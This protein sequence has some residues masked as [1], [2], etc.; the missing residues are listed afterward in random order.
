MSSPTGAI[1]AP[2]E[3]ARRPNR[4]ELLELVVEGVAHG[5]AGVARLERY[6]LFVEGAFPGERVRAEVTRSKRD[7]AHARAV[8]V[9]DPSPDRV[10]VRCDHEGGECPGSPWQTLRYERQLEHKEELVGDALRRIGGLEGFE[11][12]PIVAAAD[13]W[14]YRNKTEYSF[15]ARPSPNPSAGLPADGLL[16]GFHARGRW[17]RVNDARDCLLASERN[18]AVRNFVRDWCAAQG[19]DPLDRRTQTGFLRNLVVREGRRTGDLQVRLVTSPGEFDVDGLG[20]ALGERFPEASFL[21]TRTS[22]TA[23]VTDDGTTEVVSG[24]DTLTERLGDLEFNISPDAFF[25]PNTETAESLYALACDYAD[26]RGTE[27]VYDLFCGIGTLSLTLAMRAGEVWGVELVEEAVADAIRNAQLNEID[28]THFFH[29]DVRDSV[30][31]L[32]ERAPRPDVV[33][34]DPPRA[35][36]SKKVVRRLI[37]TRP[38]RIVYVSC[39]PTTLAPNAAQMAE[40]G[41]RLARVR[42]VDMFPHTPHIECVALLERTEGD[43]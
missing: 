23:E 2:P 21:W 20:D 35:G 32:A 37:E 4:G 33:V 26:L 14:R 16:L 3:R 18:N 27:R 11:L 6:V 30:R 39:N 19:L 42:P 28:N 25:Q 8:E 15:G 12:E 29:G 9:L 36:L 43:G 34:V 17:D 10:P 22:A 41:Y 38:R 40:A 5:G 31:P 13:P 1:P 24:E 7:Y